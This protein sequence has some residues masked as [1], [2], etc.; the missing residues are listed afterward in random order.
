MKKYKELLFLKELK[1]IGTTS[2][3]KKYASLLNNISDINELIDLVLKQNN[4]ISSEDI[5]EAKKIAEEK[6]LEIRHLSDNE[7][8]F[9]IITIFDKEYPNKLQVLENKK[10]VIIYVKG[11]L[12]A[13]DRPS[14]AVIGT[15][16]PSEWS[17]KVG[18][19]LVKKI[20]ELSGRTIVSGLAVGCDT[21]AHETTVDLGKMT[22]AILPS[23]VETIMPAVNKELARE[24]LD[25][26]GCLVSEYEPKEKA[27]QW[28]Y[29]ERDALIAA[30]SDATL[31][32][33]TKRKGGTI[34]TVDKAEKLKRRLACYY[35]IDKKKGSYEGNYMM[36]EEKG[37]I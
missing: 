21:I 11:N 24:I 15:R 2:I 25:N 3:N 9:K 13:M 23:G 20:I 34:H 36:V 8:K 1:G 30:L 14:I 31:V 16:E 17:Q 5:E 35:T 19:N 28:T 27:T 32:I 4:K 29:V 26:N 22:V 33:E 7:K 18:R 37:S 6:F 12:K 10:P